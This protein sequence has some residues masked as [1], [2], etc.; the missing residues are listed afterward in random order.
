MSQSE[1]P[2]DTDAEEIKKLVRQSLE[3]QVAINE[4]LDQHALG[5]NA[6]G[7]NLQ[8]L[9]DNTKG[10]FQFFSSP[11]FMAQMGQMMSSGGLNATG[12]A[13]E[14]AGPAEGADAGRGN[15]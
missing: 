8:W 6:I 12:P 3:G 11:Q 5:I 10:L 15:D 4:R 13:A 14:P 9:V 1:Y 7:Q 2:A